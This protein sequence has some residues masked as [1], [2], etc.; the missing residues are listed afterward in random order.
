[1]QQK[2]NLPMKPWENQRSLDGSGGNSWTQQKTHLV[3]PANAPI[4]E[5]MVVDDDEDMPVT[6]IEFDPT[7][8]FVW[9]GLR[10]C[11]PLPAHLV[12]PSVGEEEDDELANG[13]NIPRTDL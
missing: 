7:C 9:K 11:L 2:L 8:A 13:G 4:I 10:T 3:K 5:A 6:V 12:G 1:M